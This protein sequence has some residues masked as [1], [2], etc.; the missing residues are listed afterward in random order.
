MSKGKDAFSSKAHDIQAEGDI[1]DL[2]R[3]HSVPNIPH[4]V[5]ASDVGDEK[6]H[7]SQTSRFAGKYSHHPSMYRFVPHR[8]YRLVLDTIGT[9][10]EEF[11]S[12]KELVRAVHASVLGKLSKRWQSHNIS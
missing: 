4:C 9:K 12:S 2:L 10:L 3:K 7:K 8:H 1:Y 5:L 11:G 6:Y